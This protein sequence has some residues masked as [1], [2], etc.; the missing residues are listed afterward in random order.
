MKNCHKCDE[1]IVEGYSSIRDVCPK[2]G[3]D[4]HVCKN[5]VFFDP[6]SYNECREP[7]SEWVG[8]KEKNNFCDYYRFKVEKRGGN[9]KGDVDEAKQRLEALF[10]K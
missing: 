9:S 3:S 8:D 2:C 4:L 6:M 10:K 5:C 1:P 7:Q